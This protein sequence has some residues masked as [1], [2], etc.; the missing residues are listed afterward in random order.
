MKNHFSIFISAVLLLLAS[1]TVSAQ[2]NRPNNRNKGDWEDSMKAEKIAFFTD[3]LE[4]TSEEAE[5]FWPVYNKC[6]KEKRKAFDAQM[7]AFGELD[8]AVRNNKS[9]G[10]I[11][12]LL[13]AYINSMD[14][15]NEID[16]Q[17]I[18]EYKK[19]ISEQKIAKLF[20]TEETFRRHQLNKLKKGEKGSNG[21]R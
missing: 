8:E 12:T 10:E 2:E 15:R 14:K 16:R 20:L 4:L 9:A 13:D 3:A 6:D 1:S 17:Y 18:A 11:S 5:K 19:I 21:G 7:K